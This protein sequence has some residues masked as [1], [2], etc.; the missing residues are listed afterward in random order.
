MSVTRSNDLTAVDN[1]ATKTVYSDTVCATGA[2]PITV[3]TGVC[4]PDYQ[5]MVG[6][7]STTDPTALGNGNYFAQTYVANPNP[8][9]C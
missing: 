4:Y 2:V 6:T 7:C 5:I 9:V 1:V 3:D 8:L